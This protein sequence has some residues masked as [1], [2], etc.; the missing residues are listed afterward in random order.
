MSSIVMKALQLVFFVYMLL[1]VFQASI[2]GDRTC[3]FG[4]ARQTR[5]GKLS[6]DAGSAL[7]AHEIGANEI[8][9]TMT[10]LQGFLRTATIAPA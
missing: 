10:P 4:F 2:F 3:L 9:T 1:K 6:V 8:V 7:L 5:E